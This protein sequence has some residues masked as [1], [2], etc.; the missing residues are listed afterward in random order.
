MP[1]KLKDNLNGVFGMVEMEEAAK[2]I[3]Q[4]CSKTW[5]Q[6]FSI[7]SFTASGWEMNGFV[8]LLY[9]GWLEH[10]D[11]NGSFLVHKNFIKRVQDHI[12]EVPKELINND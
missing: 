12:V 1:I 3:I 6:Q 8:E 4:L 7:T 10:G 2:R 11:Y 9:S 5:E